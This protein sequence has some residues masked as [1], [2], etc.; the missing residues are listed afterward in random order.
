MPSEIGLL[1]DQR[2]HGV[3]PLRMTQAGQSTVQ[4]IADVAESIPALQGV[5]TSAYAARDIRKLRACN[6]FIRW[7]VLSRSRH[8]VR[9]AQASSYLLC[10]CYFHIL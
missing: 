4:R 7:Q 8:F 10:F 5:T 9:L 1:A 2:Y 6:T 3:D